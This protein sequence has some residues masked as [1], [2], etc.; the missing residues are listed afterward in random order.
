MIKCECIFTV[1]ATYLSILP[2]SNL[3]VIRLDYAPGRETTMKIV[4]SHPIG[5]L[6]LLRACAVDSDILVYAIPDSTG[7]I[8]FT[9]LKLESGQEALV[10]E[11]DSSED[12]VSYVR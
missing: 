3:V 10:T 2:N 7:H 5:H 1:I 12:D 8:Y 6:R 4:L 11:T 9:S